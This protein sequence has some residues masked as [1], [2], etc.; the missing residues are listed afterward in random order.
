M[1]KMGGMELLKRIVE[2]NPRAGFL[3]RGRAGQDRAGR[4]RQRKE[5]IPVA[6]REDLGVGLHSVS[7]GYLSAFELHR[8]QTSRS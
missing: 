7:S 2:I 3:Y 8:I 1:P 5:E 6:V 4:I